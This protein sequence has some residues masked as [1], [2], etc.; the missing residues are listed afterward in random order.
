MGPPQ[1]LK[2]RL[3]G[4]QSWAPPR[5]GNAEHIRATPIFKMG[6]PKGTPL[7][8]PLAGGCLEFMVGS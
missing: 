6:V 3:W 1:Q 4:H 2:P 7:G 5:G 8:W